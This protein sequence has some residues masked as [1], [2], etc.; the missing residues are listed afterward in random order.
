VWNARIQVAVQ[1][2]RAADRFAHKIIGIL[3]GFGS[4]R[5]G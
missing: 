5:G 2:A 3:K 1:Q 4:A